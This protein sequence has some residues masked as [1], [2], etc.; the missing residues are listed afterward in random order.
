MGGGDWRI[1]DMAEI[2][3]DQSFFLSSHDGSALP[4]VHDSMTSCKAFETGHSSAIEDAE[5]SMVYR[6]R[7]Q[8]S[9]LHLSARQL[10]PSSQLC[11]IVL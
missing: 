11:G 1:V 4:V 5:T 8:T 10:D 9:H 2:T 3:P 6:Q 7:P